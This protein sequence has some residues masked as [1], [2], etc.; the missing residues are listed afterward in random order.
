HRKPELEKILRTSLK[1]IKKKT[2][3]TQGEENTLTEL[4]NRHSIIIK[5]ADK[6]STIVIMDKTDYTWEAMRQEEEYYKSLEKPIYP[7][8]QTKINH[9]LK[10]L[11][12]RKYINRKQLLFLIRPD[13]G[14]FTYFQKSKKN[15]RNGQNHSKSQS[16][17]PSYP[18]AASNLMPLLLTLK[19][20]NMDMKNNFKKI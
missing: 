15:H 11:H 20:V 17:G 10:Q 3:L 13:P 19:P 2:N 5:P 18:T 8:T 1:P 6:G 7:E 14:I 16:A 9:L 4:Q 12:K